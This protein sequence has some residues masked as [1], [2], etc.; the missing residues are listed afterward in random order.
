MHVPSNQIHQVSQVHSFVTQQYCNP[1]C[2]NIVDIYYG[3]NFED[4]SIMVTN[5]YFLS[6]DQ[7]QFNNGFNNSLFN[8]KC[9]V[10]STVGSRTS[11]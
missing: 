2:E 4:S 7:G 11:A 5:N 6:I 3:Y 10:Q 8:K 9:S 1:C